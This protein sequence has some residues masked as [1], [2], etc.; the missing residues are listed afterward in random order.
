MKEY[1]VQS[2]KGLHIKVNFQE[3]FYP[4]SFTQVAFIS[5]KLAFFYMRPAVYIVYL[6]FSTC[7]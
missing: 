1:Y 6:P 5:R 7:S 3:I 4:Q 2:Y